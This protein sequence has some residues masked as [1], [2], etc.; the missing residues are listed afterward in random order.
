MPK[1][2]TT[3]TRRYWL[4]KS[5]PQD[6][7]F[8]D[9]LAKPSKRSGWDGV[10]NHQARNFMRDA[11]SVGDGVLF[12][13]SSAEPPGVAGIARIAR[14]AYPDPTQF[15]RASEHYDPKAEKDSP[16]WL[17]VDVQAVAKL[18]VFVPL[19]RLRAEAALAGMLLLQRGQRLSILPVSAEEWRAVLTLGGLKS[20]Q[21]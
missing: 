17:Q 5:E 19:A 16:T 15:E 3:P 2:K 20:D 10:R 7:S 14:A 18:P 11:M 4:M 13:H 21:V 8:D 12:Y 1:A 9:L 6:F